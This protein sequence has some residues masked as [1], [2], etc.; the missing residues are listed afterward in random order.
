[1]KSESVISASVIS[2][3]TG[4]TLGYARRF[5][6]LRVYKKAR[7]LAREVFFASKKCFP[8]EE[9]FSLTDQIR[10]ASRSVG[11]QLAEAWAKRRYPAHFI[12]KLTDADGE[13]QETQHWLTVAFDC[14]Y[15]SAE[16]T[17]RLGEL[18]L[19]VGRMLGEMTAKADQFC[20]TNDA[21]QL[22]EPP[23]DYFIQEDASFLT[24]PIIED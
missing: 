4:Q 19:E 9:K 24:A 20:Q 17:K 7:V 13:Q 3:P 8:S 10:R 22:Q 2:E 15:F 18:C 6:D 12:S 16:E 1:M 5:Q 23:A 14:G 11:G 21:G